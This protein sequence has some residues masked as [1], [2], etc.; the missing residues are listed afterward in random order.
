[1]SSSRSGYRICS[2]LSCLET[3]EDS[4]SGRV[5]AE[6]QRGEDHLRVMGAVHAATANN[7]MI[8]MTTRILVW[9]MN[10]R[11]EIQDWT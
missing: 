2:S 8:V 11:S 7:A 3:S 6:Y 5:N 4:V 1:M 9:K 10:L